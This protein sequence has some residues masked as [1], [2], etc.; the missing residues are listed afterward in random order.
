MLAL[1]PARGGSKGLPGK[2]IKMFNGQ[3]LISYT[4]QAAREAEII[5]RIIVSTDDPDIASI[6]RE[7]GAEIPFMRPSELAADDSPALDAYL[8]TLDRLSKEEGKKYDDVV[9]LLPTAPLRTSHDIDQASKI[10]FEKNADS[11]I[12]V[13]ETPHPPEWFKLIDDK[14]VLRNYRTGEGVENNRNRQEYP[15]T[16]IPN[17]AIFIFKTSFLKEKRTYYSDK[18]FPYLMA[19]E[20]SIDI[21]D[22]V[23][24]TCAEVLMRKQYAS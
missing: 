1:I 7:Y 9:I 2:N 20:K 11:V 14:G 17:G 16:Y 18:T 5:D 4:I 6:A 10:F 24:F 8:Y 15:K 21:D 12:S 3:P 22:I 13:V 19:K 23:D